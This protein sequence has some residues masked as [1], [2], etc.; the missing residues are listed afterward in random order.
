MPIHAFNID[1]NV[2]DQILGKPKKSAYEII[3]ELKENYPDS[4]VEKLNQMLDSIQISYNSKAIR[5][6]HK[7]GFD[8]VGIQYIPFIWEDNDQL[9]DFFGKRH[10][11]RNIDGNPY[12]DYYGGYIKNRKDWE[13]FPKYDPEKEY[14]RAK[15]FYKGVLRQ[16]KDIE[17]KI[18]IIAQDSLTSVFPPVW[19][20]MGMTN[21]ARALKSDPELIE[22]RFR[23]TTDYVKIIFKAFHDCGAKIFP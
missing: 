9:T 10:Y 11:V 19:Q 20:G 12:P 15:R 2:A 3:T 6:G 13:A 16:I 1:G 17:D 5:A 18:C 8:A 14:K 21:F 22:E 23:Y 4:Y 7:I